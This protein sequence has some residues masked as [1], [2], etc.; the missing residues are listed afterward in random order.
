MKK[1]TSRMII[2]V[3]GLWFLFALTI[4]PSGLVIANSNYISIAPSGDVTGQTDWMNIQNAFDTVSGVSE[5]VIELVAGTFYIHQS[6]L[7]IN[8]AGHFKGA[9]KDVT[10]IETVTPLG[11]FPLIDDP[12]GFLT[13]LPGGMYFYH[14]QNSPSTKLTPS[15]LSFSDFSLHIRGKSELW[16]SHGEE[17]LYDAFNGLSVFGKF[18]GI[19]DDEVSYLNVNF[20]RLGIEG[21]ISDDFYWGFN[22]LNGIQFGGEYISVLQDDGLFVYYVKT[23]IGNF[24]VRDCTFSDI[25]WSTTGNGVFQDSTILFEENSFDT[26]IGAITVADF[27]NSNVKIS[28]NDMTDVWAAG[29]WVIQAMQSVLGWDLGPYGPLP[30]LSSVLINHNTIRG[31][32]TADGVILEDWAFIFGEKTL[33]VLVSQNTIILDSTYG[34]IYGLGVQEAIITNNRISGIG[35]SGIYCGFGDL[36]TNWM[37]KGN[38]VQEFNAQP[39]LWWWEGDSAP[40]ILGWTTYSCTVVGGS[41]KTNVLDFGIDNYITGVNT[42]QGN[43]PGQDIQEAMHHKR[44]LVQ[45]MRYI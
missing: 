28:H 19:E 7:G 35:F 5:A 17:P 6:I 24:S 38:N 37:I 4:L 31:I 32:N 12:N 27:S 2:V 44:D 15:T 1:T 45:S 29:T 36:S 11:Y 42:I 22:G 40:I 20:E 33:D 23:I 43:P 9:G 18:T 39:T 13:G 3:S 8:F 41:S 10:I 21:E 34:G 26:T 16:G 30:E 25:F 14:D